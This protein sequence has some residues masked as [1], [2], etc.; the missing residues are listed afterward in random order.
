MIENISKP[1]T[2]NEDST[3]ARTMTTAEYLSQS[4]THAPVFLSLDTDKQQQLH[5]H[6]V[7]QQSTQ[8][9]SHIN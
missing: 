4:E 3:P 1:H 5:D 8:A 9:Q 2:K 7:H 6:Q